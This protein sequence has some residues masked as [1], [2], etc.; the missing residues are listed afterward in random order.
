MI[1]T[2]VRASTFILKVKAAVSGSKLPVLDFQ[3]LGRRTRRVL[4]YRPWSFMPEEL[5][6]K[7]NGVMAVRTCTVRQRS[8]FNAMRTTN[9]SVLP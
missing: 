8:E 1:L 3:E 5:L 4:R 2:G 6:K 9:C 7:S